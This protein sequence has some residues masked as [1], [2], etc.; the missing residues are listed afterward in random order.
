MAD[1]HG[2]PRSS[3]VIGV[4]QTPKGQPYG[5][6]VQQSKALAAA[7]LSSGP[8]SPPMRQPSAQVPGGLKPGQIPSLSD[9]TARPDEPVTAGLPL[10]A[11]PGPEALGM[12]PQAPEDLSF[13]RAL[14]AK[15]K[16]PDIRR[17]IQWAENQL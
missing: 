5:T 2:G 1:Q 16:S 4:G 7:P 14:Y 15:Y 6:G 10:G 8:P 11:G 12:L 9:P 13:A 3:N 17:L